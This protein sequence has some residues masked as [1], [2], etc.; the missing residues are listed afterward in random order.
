MGVNRLRKVIQEVFP[1]AAR[2]V[3]INVKS[4]MQQG[5]P[6]CCP[7]NV[8]TPTTKMGQ[9]SK[10]FVEGNSILHFHLGKNKYLYTGEEKS[11]N[12][13]DSFFDWL[14]YDVEI[15]KNIFDS[16]IEYILDGASPLAKIPLQRR[17]RT[18]VHF[19]KFVLN[20]LKDGKK[21]AVY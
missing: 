12:I 17:A 1:S 16:D 15:C 10:V 4:K 3:S 9:Y 6:L 19:S 14:R 5:S 7:Y 11:E 20:F 8:E 21:N 13:D 18:E 2:R